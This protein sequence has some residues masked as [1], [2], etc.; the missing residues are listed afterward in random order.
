MREGRGGEGRGERGEEGRGGGE[1]GSRRG[2]KGGRREEKGVEQ[3]VMKLLPL[4]VL[5]CPI[6]THQWGAPFSPH[7]T[8][9]ATP[10]VGAVRC[11]LASIRVCVPHSGR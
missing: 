4:C 9:K 11:G 1:E 2:E 7:R 5:P 3:E 10:W 6:G 8:A